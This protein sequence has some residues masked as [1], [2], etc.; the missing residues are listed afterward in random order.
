M[1]TPRQLSFGPIVAIALAVAVLAT[2]CGSAR[3]SAESSRASQEEAC[4]TP[5]SM[6][7]LD[8]EP[9]YSANYLHRWTTREGCPVHLDILMTRRGADSCGGPK[10]AD[11]LIGW[12]LGSS[13]HDHQPYR[14]FVRDP[15]N[16]LRDAETSSAFDDDAELPTDAVDTGY[17]Q[18]GT[19]LWMRPDDDAFVYLVLADRVERWPYDARPTGCL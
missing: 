12:P 6:T 5:G 13:H 18:D 14:I 1:P 2:A 9:S 8:E 15:H 3:Q 11:I 4:G 16:V 19:E 10:A 17:R 7:D